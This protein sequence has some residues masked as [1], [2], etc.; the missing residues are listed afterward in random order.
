MDVFAIQDEIATAI[1]EKMHLSLGV[2]PGPTP[3]STRSVAAYEALLEGRHYFSQ[4]PPEGAERALACREV[5]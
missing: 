3:P 5:A 2:A 1:V 4:F